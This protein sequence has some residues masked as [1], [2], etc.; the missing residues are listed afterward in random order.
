MDIHHLTFDD[1]TFDLVTAFQTHFHW[2]DLTLALK[3]IRRVLK[4]NATFL[5]ACETSKLNYFLPEFKQS[6]QFEMK[7]K[8]LGFTMRTHQ[9][10]RQWT[11]YMFQ[12]EHLTQKNK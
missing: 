4:P 10:N 11:L 6:K 9:K 3:E 7:M 8:V 2:D 1:N 12:K 5:L